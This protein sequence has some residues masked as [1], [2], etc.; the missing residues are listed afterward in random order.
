MDQSTLSRNL[1]PLEREGWV[2]ISPGRDRRRR[3]VTL[4]ASGQLLLEQAI[5][6]WEQVQTTLL[7]HYGQENWQILLTLL[8]EARSLRKSEIRWQ[9]T[10]HMHRLSHAG[11]DA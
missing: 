8:A 3:L 1:K 11:S 2:E 5:P 9:K 10:M 7:E 4:T 6:L